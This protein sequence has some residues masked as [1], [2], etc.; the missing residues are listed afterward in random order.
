[1]I[2][3]VLFVNIHN[4]NFVLLCYGCF[5]FFFFLISSGE[6]IY[7]K[8]LKFSDARKLCC[9]LP[10]IQ[11]KRPNL[12]VFHQK[13]ADGIPTVKTQIRLLLEEQSDLGLHCL[14]RPNC[15]KTLDHYGKY[16]FDDN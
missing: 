15:P 5:S 14:P 10:K 2:I 12:R 13:D 3:L 7:R 9:N 6:Q 4:L 11:E 16:V 8:I 1:M